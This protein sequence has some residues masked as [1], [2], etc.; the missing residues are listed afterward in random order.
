M[1]KDSSQISS[2][3]TKGSNHL[4][5]DKILNINSWKYHYELKKIFVEQ[6][7]DIEE[8]KAEDIDEFLHNYF[9]NSIS[10]FMNKKK[11]EKKK[12]N[13][14]LYLKKFQ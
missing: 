14:N 4:Y 7:E 13:L 8:E 6:L 11:K 1:T 2:S 12:F 10:F 3:V 5:S 9:K